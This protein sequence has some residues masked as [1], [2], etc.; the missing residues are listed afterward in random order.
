MSKS[1]KILFNGIKHMK[2]TF[3]QPIYTF[4]QPIYT[5]QLTVALFYMDKMF[6]Q[7]SKIWTSGSEDPDNFYDFDLHRSMLYD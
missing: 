7:E 4:S 3:S 1:A 5:F 2:T 6:I